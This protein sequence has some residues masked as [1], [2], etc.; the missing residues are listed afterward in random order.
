VIEIDRKLPFDFKFQ[1][2]LARENL[3]LCCERMKKIDGIF[4]VS[5]SSP[6]GE[7]LFFF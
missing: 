2:V 6:D 3:K 1:L 7:N 5:G 4:W